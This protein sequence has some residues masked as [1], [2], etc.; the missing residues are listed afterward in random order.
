MGSKTSRGEASLSFPGALRRLRAYLCGDRHMV[1]AYPP[2][3]QAR[4]PAEAPAPAVP[5][6]ASAAAPVVIPRRAASPAQVG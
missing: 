6:D 2:E 5:V 1:G 4:P 3:W